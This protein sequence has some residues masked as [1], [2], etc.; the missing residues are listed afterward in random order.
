M[1][2]RTLLL[3]C[4]LELFASRGYDGVGVQE[5]VECAGVTK[6]T[7]YHYFGSK[8]GL[9]TELL[10][11]FHAPFIERLENA[12]AYR[13][14]LPYTLES[15]ARC[16]FQFASEN[17]VY[18]RLQL[19]LYFAP[20]GSEASRA[21]AQWNERQHGLI[22]A[23][24]AQAVVQHGNMRGRQR[25]FA[26]TFTGLMNTCIGLWLNGYTRLDDELLRSALRQFQHGIYS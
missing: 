26:A 19:A 16:F 14:D 1:D 9:L 5:I 8:Y 6:P 7:L 13:G 11:S 24:F 20:P 2:N 15:I 10:E 21:V 4:A 3:N 17:P 18:Y 25:L 23:V 12:C 22:E